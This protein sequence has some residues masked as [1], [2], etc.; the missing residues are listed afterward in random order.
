MYRSSCKYNDGWSPFVRRLISET[1][2]KPS[3]SVLAIPGLVLTAMSCDLYEAV[4]EKLAQLKAQ[5]P[6]T[7]ELL[8]SSRHAGLI[9]SLHGR[10]DATSFL[11]SVYYEHES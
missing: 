5:A 6:W 7:S 8:F 9:S 11:R 10:D 4:K 3:Q 2:T 1:G